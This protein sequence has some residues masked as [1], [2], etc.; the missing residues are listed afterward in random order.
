MSGGCAAMW[1]HQP[2]HVH[3]AMAMSVEATI[4]AAH[5][6]EEVGRALRLPHGVAGLM[7][8]ITE[9]DITV[10]VPAPVA[11]TVVLSTQ[12]LT[13]STLTSTFEFRLVG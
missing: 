2:V 8:V 9:A 10:P 1:S 12:T 6:M 5:T 11:E 3:N 13:K 7:V 4:Q